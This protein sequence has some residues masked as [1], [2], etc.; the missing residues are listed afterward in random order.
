MA[1]DDKFKG[2]T[3]E[4]KEAVERAASWIGDLFEHPERYPVLSQASPGEIRASF[5]SS[6]PR[7]G[8]PLGEI[9]DD[10]EEK[11]VPGITHWNHPSFFAYFSITGSYPGILGEFLSAALNVNGMMWRTSPALTELEMLSLD[12]IRQLLG[13]DDSH[14]GQILDTASTSTLVAMAAARESLS[15]LQIR[16]RGMAG[17]PDVPALTV[18]TSQEAHSSV[19][20]AA[21]VVG[22]GTENIR[23]ISVDDRFRMDPG[24][25]ER[26]IVN[27]LN[28]G[29]RPLCVVATVGTTSTTSV[30]P[31]PAIWEVCE[32]HGVWLHV[33][34][35][36]AWAAAILPEMRHIFDGC[37][38]ADS[39]VVNPHKWLFT[40]I[41]LSIFYCRHKETLRN[42][43]SL[44]PEYLR[45]G[46]E[47]D[48]PNLMDY[49]FQLGRRFRALKL[50]MVLN[51]YG[52][53]GIST[54]LR[55]HIRLAKGFADWAQRHPDFEVMA[56]ADF[57]TV[58]FRF[59]PSSPVCSE[60]QLEDLNEQLMSA[61]NTSGKAFISHTRIQGRL[62]LRCAIGN[63]RTN[64]S[65]VTAL[66]KLLESASGDLLKGEGPPVR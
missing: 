36:Y 51:Y 37:P 41:D 49:S 23:R 64:Q 9:L 1:T 33:D 7:R 14:F 65:H 47:M 28:A 19:D 25:L 35:A 8:R 31:V 12:Y 21:I 17:R 10:F 4:F 66:Q 29:R 42:A 43:F 54:R 5:P 6:P 16:R 13:L 38:R 52:V 61:V 2:E 20:K 11:I 53:E 22:V 50:W 62:A 57:S 45:S 46:D 40:P 48:Q 55:E 56:P 63:I 26:A 27:D 60:Q 30:D 39:I 18:Y 32:R 34:A 59:K 44:V 15:H 24:A 3:S 58:C